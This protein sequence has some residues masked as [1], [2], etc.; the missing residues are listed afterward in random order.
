MFIEGRPIARAEGDECDRDGVALV[1]E[2]E[3][4]VARLD[5]AE[6]YFHHGATLGS[7]PCFPSFL[8]HRIFS[9]SGFP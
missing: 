3:R 1:F 2:K 7:F 4:Q 6:A 5:L 8:I 9:L